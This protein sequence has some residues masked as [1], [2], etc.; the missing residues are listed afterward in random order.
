MLMCVLF[1]Y[2]ALEQHS[3]HNNMFY[4]IMNHA[5]SKNL[6]PSNIFHADLIMSLFQLATDR[7]RACSYDASCAIRQPLN[8]YFP[9]NS[10]S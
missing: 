2:S 5:E 8:S 10:F 1:C 6:N 4:D 3:H 9:T 7:V